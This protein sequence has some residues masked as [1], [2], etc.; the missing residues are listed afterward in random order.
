MVSTVD[1]RATL[2]GRSGP[3]S[4]P[5]DRQLF[6]A[7]RAPAD[8]I[9]VGAGTVR[10]EHYGRLI[11]DAARRGARLDRG[12]TDE[13][14]ACI[15]SGS[16]QL[17][18]TTPLLAEPGARVLVITPSAG[19][20]PANAAD[21]SYLRTGRD[22]VLDLGRAMAELSVRFS[23]RL[24]LCEGGPHLAGELLA[25]GLLDELFLSLSPK[26]AGG[27]ERTEQAMRI[28]SGD[29]LVPPVELELLGAL[30]SDSHLFL[31]YGVVAPERLS[32]DGASP[33]SDAE[34]S[35]APSADVPPSS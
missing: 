17:D 28:L 29:E 8:A 22:G 11:P 31:R 6:H 23:V 10:S 5:A 7:L 33:P 3:L 1:G 18:P 13:P 16:L 26:L 14:L 27:A 25:A 34:P 2:H 32:G 4:G 15:V 20:I 19:E 12:L 35:S 9:L 30:E 24:L 21:V